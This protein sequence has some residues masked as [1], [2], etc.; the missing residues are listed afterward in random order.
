MKLGSLTV[1]S[2]LGLA[3]AAHA[4]GS[5]NV[6]FA[7]FFGVFVV[8]AIGWGIYW[9]AKKINGGGRVTDRDYASVM[10]L[11]LIIFFIVGF[12]LS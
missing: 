11:L 10:L 4:R 5:G 3:G 9:I 6:D 2:I 12:A 8:V 7:G 1:I